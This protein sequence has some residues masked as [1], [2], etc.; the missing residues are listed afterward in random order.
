M[1]ESMKARV[2]NDKG[3]KHT[4]NMVSKNRIIKL[5]VYTCKK[6]TKIIY[7]WKLVICF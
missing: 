2:K 6:G 3:L 5:E 4:K 1:P 7:A